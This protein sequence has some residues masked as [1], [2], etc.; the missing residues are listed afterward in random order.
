MRRYF[1]SGR[2]RDS[3]DLNDEVESG[4]VLSRAV[5]DT[6][7]RMWVGTGNFSRKKAYS[8]RRFEYIS[9]TSVKTAAGQF[10]G[11][12]RFA[13]T[14]QHDAQGMTTCSWMQQGA[15]CHSCPNG[16]AA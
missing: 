8:S 16:A 11:G 15:A 9:P 13:G 2:Y 1:V 7:Q 5:A 3:N 14:D 12:G 10:A 4:G 6:F